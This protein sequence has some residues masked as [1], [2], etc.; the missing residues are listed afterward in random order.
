MFRN[1]VVYRRFD[2][3]C[4][5]VASAGVR[6][7][8]LA[9]VAPCSAAWAWRRKT[10]AGARARRG[11]DVAVVARGPGPLRMAPL[12][13]DGLDTLNDLLSFLVQCKADIFGRKA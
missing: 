13:I 5:R 2:A 8:F 6:G 12:A 3:H 9:L 1:P 7:R 11:N 10:S 4:R